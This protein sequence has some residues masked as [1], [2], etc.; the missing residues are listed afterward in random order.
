MIRTI[1]K[2]QGEYSLPV[3]KYQFGV[4]VNEIG[5]SDEKLKFD[6]INESELNKRIALD[7]LALVSHFQPEPEVRNQKKYGSFLANCEKIGPRARAELVVDEGHSYFFDH[8]LDHVP[9]ILMIHACEELLEWYIDEPFLPTGMNIRFTRFLE[10]DG[11]TTLTLHEVEK[12]KF[13]FD[14]LQN[15][16]SVGILKVNA[17]LGNPGIIQSEVSSRILSVEDKKYT[18]KHRSENILVSALSDDDRFFSQARDLND[19]GNGFF[20][21]LLRKRQSMLYFGEI[22]RQF[23]MLMAHLEKKIPL[24]KKMNLISIDLEVSKWTLPPFDLKLEKFDILDSEKFMLADVKVNFINRERIFGSG[25][26]KA[27]VVT[28]E[29]YQKQR[30]D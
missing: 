14:I 18:H 27:Q 6:L 5:Q 22:T 3:G 25:S 29:Y 1:Q 10:K 9:G 21:H 28:K 8:P 30:G 2:G 15:D 12:G 4:C 16:R 7:Y 24:E 26:L 13:E 17:V 23:V 11:V 19:A 20:H